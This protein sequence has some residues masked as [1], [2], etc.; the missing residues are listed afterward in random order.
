MNKNTLETT[1]TELNSP[2]LN[3]REWLKTA[4]TAVAGLALASSLAPTRALAQHEADRSARSTEPVRLNSNEN[5]FGPSP[6]AM[7]AVLQTADRMLRY[8]H[9]EVAKL[10]E[11]I[12]AK[13]GVTEE[14]LALGCGSAEVL[15]KL[16]DWLGPKKGE[17]VCSNLTFNFFPL[18]IKRLGA[19]LVEV[20]LD[21]TLANDLDAMAAKV[22]AA[23]TC[24][25]LC[26]PNNP[27][28]TLVK[29]AKLKAFVIET[30]KKCPV[31]IDEAYL[32]FADDYAGNTMVGLVKEGHNVIVTRTFSKIYGLAGERVGYGVMQPAVAKAAFA[33]L[34]LRPGFRLNMLGTVA[35]TA[36]LDDKAYVEDTRAKMKGERDKL[37]AL[38]KQLGKKFAE[39]Q[40]NFVY[41]LPGIPGKEFQAKMKAENILTGGT[42]PAMPEWCRITVGLPE[43]MAVLHE[44]IKKTFA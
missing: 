26:N 19:T 37:C 2:G 22:T 9:A 31:I 15:E 20:P 30:A 44:A 8:P 36:S 3:R 42:Y 32:D 16:A 33:H 21:A 43:E 34:N 40:G 41:F 6:M 10:T 13:E 1:P 5:P 27:T 35:A 12:A 7:A 14:H 39:P 38:L 11:A 29:A 24:V 18:A 4:G 17:V 28:G 25:Y 23:T